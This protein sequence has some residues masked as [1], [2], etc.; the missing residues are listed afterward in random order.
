MARS[1]RSHWA[2]P[3][4]FMWMVLAGTAAPLLAQDPD[5]YEGQAPAHVAFVDGVVVLER[6][7]QI[8]DAPGSMPL[9]AGDRLRTRGGRVEVLF[10]DGSTLHLDNHSV[11]DLQSDDLIR[12]VEG[13]I[14]LTIPGPAREVAYRI[15]GPQGW[16]RITEPGEYRVALL[17]APGG[18]ELELAVIRGRAELAN[19][20][21]QTPLRA[22]ERAFVRAGVAPSYAYVA[23]SAALDAFDRWS[24]RRRDARMAASAEYLP[25]EVRPYA[26]ELEQHGYWR[27]EPTYGRVWYPRV[28]ADWRPYY[29]GRWVSLR[30][31]GWTWVG[32]DPWGW[33]THHYGRWGYSAAGAWF[34]IPGRTWGAAWVSWAYAP[35]YVSWCPLGWNNRPIFQINVNVGRRYDPWRAWT[36]LPQRHFGYGSVHRNHVRAGLLDV[37]VRG[38]FAHGDR[39]PELRGHAVPRSAAPIRVAGTGSSRRGDAPLYTNLPADRGRI[40]TDG[41]RMRVPSGTA[42]DRGVGPAPGAGARE[43]ALPTRPAVR[44]ERPETPSR[45]GDSPRQEPPATLEPRADGGRRAVPRSQPAERSPERAVTSPRRST[46]PTSRQT[47]S[48]APRRSE[49][50]AT[51]PGGYPA[52]R[53]DGYPGARRAESPSVRRTES[54]S[55]GSS[56]RADAP[57]PRRPGGGAA[58][59]V[60]SGAP[61]AARPPAAARPASRAPAE[62]SAPSRQSAPGARPSSPGARP[63]GP[64]GG[65]PRGRAVPRG[66][67]GGQVQ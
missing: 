51:R 47:D 25:D 26:A 46:S 2:L 12:L 37:R 64:A 50:P 17:N 19:N 53:P 35:G 55:P 16:A 61:P 5:S 36:V 54:P 38:S 32:H 18:A 40:Q 21:G 15:D 57:A 66:G 24:D 8:D 67:G 4:L 10:A 58:Y 3:I 13:R 9:L 49:P 23:N 6:D 43:R 62:T 20:D 60:P 1:L 65:P 48:P 27:T 41:A 29:R 42:P 30:P 22:G 56:P 63:S 7:G 11:V 39:A 59:R 31:Y 34:W 14:R 45:R 28:A 44:A 52:A 33:P